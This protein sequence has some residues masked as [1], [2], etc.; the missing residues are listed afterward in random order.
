MISAA[1]PGPAERIDAVTRFLPALG[2][3]DAA[4]SWVGGGTRDDGA[5][6]MPRLAHGDV[7]DGF[8]QACN[9][10]GWVTPFDWVRWQATAAR[11]YYPD[12]PLLQRARVR[13][14]GQLLTLHVRKDRFVEGHFAGMV[15][16]GH[17]AAILRRL[18]AIGGGLR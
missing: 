13:T 7:S 6:V 16:S 1:T 3:P 14:L 18:T 17:I 5:Y 10:N 8:I 11:K 15:E 4:G 2:R 12:T 9:D